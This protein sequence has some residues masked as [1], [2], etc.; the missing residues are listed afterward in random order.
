MSIGQ[1]LKERREAMFPSMEA[2]V[3]E[4]NPEYDPNWI[5]NEL[6]LEL[7]D[8]AHLN[9]MK[10]SGLTISQVA[11][12]ADALKLDFDALLHDKLEQEKTI[13][14]LLQYF[15]PDGTGTNEQRA[16]RLVAHS[17]ISRGRGREILKC[18][19]LDT[20]T[21]LP[22]VDST[23]CNCLGCRQYLGIEKED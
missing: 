3:K 10:G 9:D 21:T 23:G 1:Q 5:K 15:D 4:L 7:E 12:I 13:D 20:P 14:E 6:V 11:S 8:V 16:A 17:V 18:G 22:H 19:I 2:F